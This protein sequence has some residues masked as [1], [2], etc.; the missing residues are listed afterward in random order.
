[1]NKM[2]IGYRSIGR[3]NGDK[4]FDSDNLGIMK[5]KELLGC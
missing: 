5:V 4:L 1:M 2:I 3:L